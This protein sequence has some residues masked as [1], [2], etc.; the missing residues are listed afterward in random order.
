M[1]PQEKFGIFVRLVQHVVLQA[2]VQTQ[3]QCAVVLQI[4]KTVH[5]VCVP[6]VH[7]LVWVEQWK[8]YI[9]VYTVDIKQKDVL[10]QERVFVMVDK[11]IVLL[12][13]VQP[14]ERLISMLNQLILVGLI[15]IQE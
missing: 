2:E 7:V 8:Y 10:I 3:H 9:I 5:S 12:A 4:T 11:T 14:A 1:L 6:W 13:V 15:D